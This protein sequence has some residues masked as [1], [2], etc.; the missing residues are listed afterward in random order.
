MLRRELRQALRGRR[1]ARFYDQVGE[2]QADLL[3]RLGGLNERFF[4]LFLRAL[5]FQPIRDINSFV[6]QW[7]LDARPLDVDALQQVVERLGQLRLTAQEVEEKSSALRAIVAQQTEVRTWRARHAEYLLLS[8]LLRREE[9]RTRAATLGEQ[10]AALTQAIDHAEAVYAEAAT[11]RRGAQ[12]ALEE[13]LRRLAQLDVVR[14]RD[15]L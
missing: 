10:R 14:R 9:M 3:N 4:D 12:A 15:E 8:A 2:Y 1:G 7:L 5:T 13:A 11:A 6:E